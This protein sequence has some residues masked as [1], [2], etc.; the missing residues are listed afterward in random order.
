MVADK[1]SAHWYHRDKVSRLAGLLSNINGEIL[2]TDSWRQILLA[3]TS[4]QQPVECQTLFATVPID[5]KVLKNHICRAL[6]PRL[7]KQHISQRE[8]RPATLHYSS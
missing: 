7:P 5:R 1:V 3:A 2:V 8:C 4:R 6:L